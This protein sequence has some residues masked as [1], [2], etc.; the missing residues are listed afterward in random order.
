MIVVSIIAVIILILSV[1]NGFREGALKQIASIISL[2][3]AIPLAGLCYNWLASLFSGLGGENWENFLGFIVTMVIIM[4]LIQLALWLPRRH[5]EKGWN[6]GAIFRLVGSAL[7]FFNAAIGMVVF[8]IVLNAYPI[9]DWLQS[10]VSGSGVINW[11]DSWLGFVQSWLPA[12]F[13]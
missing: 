3:A 13:G 12:A 2:L 6:E 10:A 11:L 7:G 5:F 4:V 8:A 9:F 1:F